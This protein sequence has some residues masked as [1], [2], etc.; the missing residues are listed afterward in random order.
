[1]SRQVDVAIIG[2]GIAGMTLAAAMNKVGIKAH[3]FEQADVFG[4]V[5]GHLTLDTAAIGVLNRW[6]FDVP[7]LEMAQELNGIEV[8]HLGSG[9]VIAHFGLPDLGSMGVE[10]PNRHGSRIVYAFL[11]ADFLKTLADLIPADQLHTGYLLKSLQD[12]TDHAEAFFENGETVRAG[13]I[14]SADGIRSIARDMF[15]ASAVAATGVSIAR[16]RAPASLLLDGMP[17]DRMRFWDGWEFGDKATNNGTHVLTA[18]VRAG[19]FVC[20]DI[21]LHGGDQMEDCDRWNLPGDRISARLPETIHDPVR[22]LFDGRDEVIVSH[23]LLDRQVANKWSGKRVVIIGDAAHAMRPTLGQ[24]ACQSIHDVGQLLQNIEEHGLNGNAFAA[25]EATRAPYVRSIV[26]TAKK[27]V[28]DPK[29]W[30]DKAKS[31]AAS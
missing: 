19:K 21:Q 5:G 6:G 8:R 1:M 14:F 17:N 22:A 29:A 9:D 28:V 23:P 2:A 25:Y 12:G 27:V 24:G 7:F 3:L 10:D 20:I 4:Q 15:D 18:P 13:A 11:R 30:K 31:A 16:T 26:D